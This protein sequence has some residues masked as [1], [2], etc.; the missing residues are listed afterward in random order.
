MDL[1]QRKL[2][3]DEWNSVEIPVSI[4]EKKIITMI[5]N[6]YNNLNIEENYS[7]SLMNFLKIGYSENMEN[8]LYKTYLKI[9]LTHKLVNTI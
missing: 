7:L 2:T 3:R 4:D 6:G 1:I 9:Q 8:H 5:T